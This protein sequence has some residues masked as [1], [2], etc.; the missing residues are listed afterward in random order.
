MLLVGD[1]RAV[2]NAR[3]QK[4]AE[5]DGDTL[6]SING[7]AVQ[8]EEKI[9]RLPAGGEGWDSKMKKKRSA[10]IVGHRVANAATTQED[11]S[12]GVAHFKLTAPVATEELKHLKESVQ[13]ASRKAK[14]RVRKLHDSINK[15]DKYREALSSKNQQRTVISPTERAG[16]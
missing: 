2:V 16:E 6:S 3:Q 15:L 7:S 11:H 13:D 1:S 4:G 9:Q 14:D 12:F 8:T 5:K 10:G